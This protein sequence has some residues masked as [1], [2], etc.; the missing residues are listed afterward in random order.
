[1]IRP[2][3]EVADIIQ[4]QGDRFVDSYRRQLSYQQLNVLRAIRRCRTAALGGHV[5][6]CPRCGQTAISY[7]SCRNRNCPK[8]QSLARAQWLADRQAELLD[9]SRAS[10]YYTPM[11]ISE[12]DLRLMRRIDEAGALESL[13]ANTS[14]AA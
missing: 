2:T 10:L 1:M 11:P 5:D 12:A 14:S 13:P 7:N 9:L 3:I 4:A 8:C 6:T